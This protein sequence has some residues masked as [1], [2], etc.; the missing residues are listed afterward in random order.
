MFS[1]SVKYFHIE[2]VR[3]SLASFS[4]LTKCLWV[5]PGAYQRVERLKD[6]SLGKAP[7]LPINIGLGWKGFPG[8]NTLA[9]LITDIYYKIGPIKRNMLVCFPLALV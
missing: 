2:L 9:S 6:A 7:A 1:N 8:T 3:H 4:N 5:R